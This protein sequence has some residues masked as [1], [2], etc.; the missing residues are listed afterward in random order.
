MSWFEHSGWALAWGAGGRRKYAGFAVGYSLVELAISLG[1][2]AV[3]APVVL[4]AM[5][6]V[7][8]ESVR[9][10]MDA[11]TPAMVEAIVAGL[12]GPGGQGRAAGGDGAQRDFALGFGEGGR[13]I[14]RVAQEDYER[15]VTDGLVTRCLAR[16]EEVPIRPRGD[17]RQMSSVRVT[18]EYPAVAARGN[19]RR[20]EFVACLRQGRGNRDESD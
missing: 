10:R 5:V 2:L 16:V 4:V 7:E 13:W 18:I 15:G 19:R 17:G 3:A 11:R 9:A 8:E 6:R 1:V 12:S 14:G 20:R